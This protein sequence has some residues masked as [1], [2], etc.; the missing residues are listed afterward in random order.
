MNIRSIEK[1]DLDRLGTFYIDYFNAEG[2]NWTR[3]IAYKRLHQMWNIDDHINLIAEQNDIICGFLMGYLEW[4]D[5]GPYFHII[6]ILVNRNYQNK[7][8]GRTLMLDAEKIAKDAGA[9]VATL[10]TLSDG[11]HEHFYGELGY[12]SKDNFVFKMKR[13]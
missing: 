12:S 6:E 10:E 2:D 9:R 3:E 8:V 5:D 7:K 13:L 11:L 1:E 4:F